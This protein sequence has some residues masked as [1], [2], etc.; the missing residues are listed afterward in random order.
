MPRLLD[1]G[2]AA[3]FAARPILQ[4]MCHKRGCQNPWRGCGPD[5]R[6]KK[7]PMSSDEAAIIAGAVENALCWGTG[8]LT[9][10]REALEDAGYTWTFQHEHYIFEN[11]VEGNT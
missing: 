4:Q 9:T 5:P 11:F 8:L 6:Q 3:I 1:V 10:A 2:W 7:T